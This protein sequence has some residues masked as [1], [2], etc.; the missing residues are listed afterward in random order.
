MKRTGTFLLSAFAFLAF[1]WGFSSA[2]KMERDTDRVQRVENGLLPGVVIK[3][4]VTTM[5]LA[6]RMAHYKVPGV[7]VAVIN[8][9]KL[10][11]AKGYGVI[12]AGSTKPVT[13]ETRFQ[14]ASISKP[15]AATA[16]LALVQQ[17]KLSLDENV[18]LKLKSWQVPDNEFTK[19]EKVT[20]RRLVSHSAGLTVHGFRGYAADEAVP[21]LVQ[22][23]DGQKPANSAPIRVNVLPGSI[24]RYSG[25]GYNVMQQMLIDVTGKPF[26]TLMQELVLSKIGMK[27]STYQQPLPKEWETMAAVGHRANGEVVKGRWHTYPEMAAAGL[28]TTPSDLARFAIELQQ[29]FQGKSNKVLSQEMVRQMLTKQK[30]DYGLGL[31]LGGK[32]KVTSFSH[33]GS[34]EGF[35]CIMFAYVETGQGAVVMTNGDRGSSL[36]TEILRAI[37]REYGWPDQQLN[38]KTLA[39]EQPELY[40]S[41]VGKYD[42]NG[43]HA[44]IST[45]GGQLF[46]TAA[47]LGAAPV[48]LYPTA[49]NRFFI[50]EDNLEVTFVK[51]AQGVVTE[52]KV[53]LGNNPVTA[54]RM[55]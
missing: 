47:P 19:D 10:E 21:A 40:P 54:K 51:D 12:E 39:P 38:E 55:P 32:E 11:W 34:N 4:Q 53:R 17:G 9:G 24:W 50:L 45:Q 36:G 52:M 6:D 14:A 29:S 41:Y 37:G 5:K 18:N 33:G 48:R 30:G 42:I 46:L 43:T 3:G 7:S 31:G 22:A 1:L 49:D 16:A 25:G 23:L 20:L 35:K 2:Q 8:N 26:P 27:H 13:T 15:V 28:W 44:T